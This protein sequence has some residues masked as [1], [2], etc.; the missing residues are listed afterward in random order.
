[1]DLI[2]AIIGLICLI[3]FFVMAYN[4]SAI[5]TLL[6][7]PK[8]T[9]KS[10]YWF[11]QFKKHY[12]WHD[13]DAALTALKEAIWLKLTNEGLTET[14][15]KKTYETLK[16]KYEPVIKELKGEFLDYPFNSEINTSYPTYN[17]I[18]QIHMWNR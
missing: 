1:M 2:A 10:A 15:R 18:S 17:S 14:E 3:C 16:E 9:S 13:S 7:Q 4:I 12:H 5:K 8:E 11:A 6:R